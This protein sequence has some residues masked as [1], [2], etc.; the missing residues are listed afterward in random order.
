MAAH[1]NVQPHQFKLFM[2]PGEIMGSVTGS[3][4]R[5]TGLNETMSEMWDRKE[6]ES[7]VPL[8]VR[9]SGEVLH[10]SGV[11]D[12]IAKEGVTSHVEIRPRVDGGLFMRNG[13]H[14]VAAAAA[15][16]RD[17]GRQQYIPVNYGVIDQSE[18]K[19]HYPQNVRKG[20]EG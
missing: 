14:R 5:W 2:T 4:D 20:W 9:R 13:H 12:S 19:K 1:D 7:R 16:E 3:G 15:V 11:Y 10:G 17:T 18:Y 6:E 8:H